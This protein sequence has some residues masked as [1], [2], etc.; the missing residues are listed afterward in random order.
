MQ[1]GKWKMLIEIP[2]LSQMRIGKED[3]L[4]KF[5]PLIPKI[6]TWRRFS[7]IQLYQQLKPPHHVVEI[8]PS[9]LASRR[10]LHPSPPYKW[11][12]SWNIRQPRWDYFSEVPLQHGGRRDYFSELPLQ[13]EARQDY[14]SKLLL[15]PRA[16]RD[17]FSELPLC[18]SGPQGGAISLPQNDCH[19]VSRH[20]QSSPPSARPDLILEVGFE[21]PAAAPGSHAPRE[22][23]Q[24]AVEP[25]PRIPREELPP[26]IIIVK[27]RVKRINV[28]TKWKRE[29]NNYSKRKEKNK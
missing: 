9:P 4:M 22:G 16:R 23:Q 21:P 24:I 17:Y 6:I 29:E 27:E 10:D 3:V 12:R 7:N 1:I 28:E 18:Q 5:F 11:P 25:A 2:M 13:P 20:Q 19:L 26:T 8:N 15:Q 14:F